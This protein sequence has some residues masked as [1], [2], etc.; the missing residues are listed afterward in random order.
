V[1]NSIRAAKIAIDRGVGG[2]L[3]SICAYGYKRPPAG[4]KI[5]LKEA[6]KGFMEFIEG[7]R[8]R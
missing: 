5:S 2:V 1:L 8:E 4:M 3:N 6:E 7:K